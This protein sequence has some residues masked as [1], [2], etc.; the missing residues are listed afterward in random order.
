MEKKQKLDHSSSRN[1]SQA[2]GDDIV[3]SLRTKNQRLSAQMLKLINENSE[4]T[5]AA[6][7]TKAENDKLKADVVAVKGDIVNLTNEFKRMVNENGA[8]N[9]KVI[10]LEKLDE[11]QSNRIL[12]KMKVSLTT[13]TTVSQE[14]REVASNGNDMLKGLNRLKSKLDQ[15]DKISLELNELRGHNQWQALRLQNMQENFEIMKRAEI[16]Q[17]KKC[18]WCQGCG[19]PDGPYYCCECRIRR[20]ETKL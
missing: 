12:R 17:V 6:N 4:L 13:L 9:S 3:N 11:K 5:S 19:K 14:L 15:Y 18:S 10:E 16:S 8:L 1:V 20:Y 7:A 2:D